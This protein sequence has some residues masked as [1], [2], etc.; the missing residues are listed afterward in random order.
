MYILRCYCFSA[1]EL[2]PDDPLVHKR[3]ADVRGK[4]GKREE[5]IADYQRAIDIETAKRKVFVTKGKSRT[6]SEAAQTV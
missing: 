2:Q 1:L 4:L 6:E 3:R 5:A